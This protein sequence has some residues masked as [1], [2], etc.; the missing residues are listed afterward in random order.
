MNFLKKDHKLVGQN[1]RVVKTTKHDVNLRKNSTIYFQV[2]LI[3]TLL[4][5]HGLFEMQFRVKPIVID[6]PP[7]LVEPDVYVNF[8]PEIKKEPVQEQKAAPQRKPLLAISFK[9]IKNETVLKEEPKKVIVEP[10]SI[11]VTDNPVKS[12]PK[13]PKKDTYDIIGVEQVPIYPGCEKYTTNDERRE[14]MSKKIGRLIGRKFNTQLGSELGLSGRQR[15]SV[16]FKINTQGNV[17]EI[18]ARAP[19]DRLEREAIKV[20]G[21]IPQMIPGKQRD[22]NV[23]VIYRLP[24][25]FQV[26]Q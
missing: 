6:N 9:Q 17:T 22:K 12:E 5:V 15:I 20:V 3:L 25:I 18:L 11:S 1:E 2:G 10:P 4:A 14:C 7:D 19:H 8:V 13:T 23:S 26:Q 24:I 16:Q 21:K